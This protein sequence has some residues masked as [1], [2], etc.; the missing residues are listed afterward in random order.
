MR[1]KTRTRLDDAH[2]PFYRNADFWSFNDKN[3]V[4][5]PLSVGPARKVL[6]TTTLKSTNSPAHFGLMWKLNS[7]NKKQIHTRADH[8]H[9]KEKWN[10]A[11]AI[12]I[13]S[14]FFS[15]LV[16][17]RRVD[18]TLKPATQLM[19]WNI[20]IYWTDYGRC[21][22]HTSVTNVIFRIFEIIWFFSYQNCS[23]FGAFRLFIYCICVT[24]WLEC[25]ERE[26]IGRFSSV[27]SLLNYRIT[28]C[29][30][31]WRL[32]MCAVECIESSACQSTEGICCT[33]HPRHTSFSAANGGEDALGGALSLDCICMRTTMAHI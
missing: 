11:F 15:F 31:N 2:V 14:I 28:F 5:C 29:D 25:A 6:P 9:G 33:V 19:R 23:I 18:L 24:R 10:E 1:L 32:R 17:R 3:D 21:A 4:T 12:A 20:G 8:S 16:A 22:V 7:N 13:N 27:L 26:W 30:L